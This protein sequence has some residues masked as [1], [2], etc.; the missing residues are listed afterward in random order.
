MGNYF[1]LHSLSHNIFSNDHLPPPLIIK[2]DSKK[3]HKI[4]WIECI[5]VNSITTATPNNTNDEKRVASPIKISVE[6]TISLKVAKIAAISGDKI[7]TLNSCLN[8]YTTAAQLPSKKLLKE[9]QPDEK[10]WQKIKTRATRSQIC[11]RCF[12]KK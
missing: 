1:F 2:P 11:E 3:T 12:S 7:G 9:D 8:K 6:K 4:C 5:Y 10:N